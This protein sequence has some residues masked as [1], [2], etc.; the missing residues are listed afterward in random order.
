MAGRPTA[1]AFEAL[2][3]WIVSA[4]ADHVSVYALGKDIALSLPGLTSEIDTQIVWTGEQ[5]MVLYT[6]GSAVRLAPLPCS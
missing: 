6:A 5:A 2:V 4:H 1:R 3:D